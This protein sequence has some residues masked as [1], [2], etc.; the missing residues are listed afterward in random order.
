MNKKS[1]QQSFIRQGRKVKDSELSAMLIEAGF[2][3]MSE[4]DYPTF[5]NM[6]AMQE[7]KVPS[8][9]STS[10]PGEFKTNQST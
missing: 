2:T 7:Y 9:L 4:I 8:Q 3:D 6:L 5:Y 1:L 10:T